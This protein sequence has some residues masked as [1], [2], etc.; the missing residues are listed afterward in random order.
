MGNNIAK[1]VHCRYTILAVLHSG[2]LSTQLQIWLVGNIL[3]LIKKHKVTQLSSKRN[4]FL[5]E[6]EF[7]GI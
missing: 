7:T 5:Y 6:P 2:E 4:A 1:A 3:D